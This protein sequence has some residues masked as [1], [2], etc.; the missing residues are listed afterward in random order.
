MLLRRM[1]PG[2]YRL[3]K[4]PSLISLNS[5]LVLL[6]AMDIRSLSTVESGKRLL[7]L[8]WSDFTPPQKAQFRG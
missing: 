7:R 4:K 8:R 1:Q 6:K 5:E 3:A 2:L